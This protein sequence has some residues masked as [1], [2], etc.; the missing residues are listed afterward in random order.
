MEGREMC[1]NNF[2]EI[3]SQ[4][5]SKSEMTEV[6][7]WTPGALDG[8][9]H[10]CLNMGITDFP[11][12]LTADTNLDFD[13]PPSLPLSFSFLKILQFL[14]ISAI[15]LGLL[16]ALAFCELG[17]GYLKQPW[18]SKFSHHSTSLAKSRGKMEGSVSLLPFVSSLS[19]GLQPRPSPGLLQ[20]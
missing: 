16:P 1:P 18:L 7:P 11:R 3:W 5:Y 6:R 10:L 20:T 4:G 19:F 14:H 9:A 17:N 2:G 8:W 15:C 12:E 13:V